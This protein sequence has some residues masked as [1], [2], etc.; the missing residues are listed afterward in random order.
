[1]TDVNVKS[2]RDVENAVRDFKNWLAVFKTEYNIADEAVRI[3]HEK[4]DAFSDS[5]K[6]LKCDASGKVDANSV[7]PVAN[8][9][10]EAKAWLATFAKE[11]NLAE[12]AVK[13]L[14]QN[15]DKVGDAL[16]AVECK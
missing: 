10:R 15:F 12:E 5:L 11:Y 14:H 6:G 9:L 4:A 3:L 7:K 8:V 1:M 13:V 16:R 2:I